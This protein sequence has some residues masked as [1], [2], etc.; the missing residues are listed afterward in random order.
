[1]ENKY[2]LRKKFFKIRK[3]N[4]FKIT[5]NFFDPLARL[6][7]KKYKNKQLN[8]SSYYPSSFEVDTLNIFKTKISSKLKFCLPVIISD[9]KIAFYE[10]KNKDI[11]KI[12]KYGMLEPAFLAKQK[13]P[14][15]MLVPLLAFDKKNN[16]LGY[17]GG[18]Y[19]RYLNKYLHIF[20]NITT[21]GVAFSF[22]KHH[23]LPTTKND[24]KLNY[25]LTEKG[26]IK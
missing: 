4:Y 19:D 25:I 24:V 7:K 14:D 17:G 22:Q 16:R 23:K 13:V 5:P 8:I 20:K 3:K 6:I 18:F 11:L 21:V 2:N 15:I 9:N 10:W 12:N 26:F 1:M